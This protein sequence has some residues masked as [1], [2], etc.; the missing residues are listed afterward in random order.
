VPQ[1]EPIKV[2]LSYAPADE[3][4][5]RELEK[6]LA[7]LQ[8]EGLIEPWH[9]RK[10][11]AGEDWRGVVDVQLE[12]AGIILILVSA[13]FLA[14]DYCN[15]VE[16]KRAL[17]RHEEAQAHVLPVLLRPCDWES[18][19]FGKLK[20]LPEGGTPVSKAN[21]QD[22]A[23][24]EVAKVV[25][26]IAERNPRANERAVRKGASRGSRRLKIN[27]GL[28]L[29]VASAAVYTIMIGPRSR[30]DHPE[31][32]EPTSV[33]TIDFPSE[34]SLI[35]AAPDAALSATAEPAA[36][37]ITPD[38]APPPGAALLDYQGVLRERKT[39]QPIR[40]A[41]LVLIGTGCKETV[42]DQAGVFVFVRCDS[43]PRLLNPRIA[44]LGLRAGGESWDCYDIPLQK[45]PAMTEVL[46]DVRT[47]SFR[48]APPAPPE[49]WWRD[50]PRPD[51]PPPR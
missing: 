49:R 3:P 37:L 23:L 28:S 22:E 13:D 2:F 50:R 31:T 1:A 9:A 45:P 20:V 42:T 47:C 46:L 32:L 8:R 29:L 44:V 43:A 51:G 15:D 6:H 25:R 10:V 21:N 24:T 33:S 35:F 18:A 11:G 12:G 34:P 41:R 39:R 19:P 5:L 7:L 40:G 36:D 16:V 14:S 26:N 30:S 48:L 17:E 4:F 38:A 27:L